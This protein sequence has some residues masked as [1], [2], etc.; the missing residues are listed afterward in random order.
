M[1]LTFIV[2]LPCK[3][4]LNA[5]NYYLLKYKISTKEI[6][7]QYEKRNMRGK[8]AFIFIYLLNIC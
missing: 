7:M 3:T 1:V 5:K 8:E 4:L 6:K 2:S